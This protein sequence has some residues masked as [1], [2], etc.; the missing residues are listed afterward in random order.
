MVILE[1]MRY[2]AHFEYKKEGDCFNAYFLLKLEQWHIEA[3]EDITLIIHELPLDADYNLMAE[4][5]RDY[6]YKNG[7]KIFVIKAGILLF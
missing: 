3:Y 1:G 5:Y 6:K 7:L 2:D 4:I